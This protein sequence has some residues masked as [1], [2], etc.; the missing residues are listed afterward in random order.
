RRRL[1]EDEEAL[2]AQMREVEM[3]MSRD[4]AELS[5]HR[6]ELQR[7]HGD[8]EREVE[9]ASRDSGLRYRLLALTRRQQD[10]VRPKTMTA[11][12]QPAEQ[13][14]PPEPSKKQNSGLFRRL[15]GG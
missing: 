8:L 2:M 9:H 7:M 1:Q 10:Q 3:A 13:A 5:R 15:F 4:R 11:L 6:A 14:P 12:P